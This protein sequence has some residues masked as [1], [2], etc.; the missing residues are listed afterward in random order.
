MIGGTKVRRSSKWPLFVGLAIACAFA[1][2]L[3]W[4]LQQRALTSGTTAAEDKVTA[5]VKQT[6]GPAVSGADLSKPLASS[7]RQRLDQKIDKGV[8]ASGPIVRVRVFSINGQLLYS[9]DAADR[10][11]S[12]AFGYPD[13]LRGA[14]GGALTSLV[15]DDS[16][17]VK[18]GVQSI[19]LLRTYAP[20]KGAKDHTIAVVAVDQRYA[21]LEQ[22]AGSPWHTVQM[23]FAILAVL[24]LGLALYGILRRSSAK[25][26]ASRSGFGTAKKRAANEPAETKRA[27][28][29]AEKS[30]EREGQIREALEDQLEQLRAKLSE[31]D[32]ATAA[33]TREL[34]EQLAAATRRAEQAEAGGPGPSVTERDAAAAQVHDAVE[35]LTQMEA[36]ALSAEAKLSKL[37]G[38]MHEMETA[39][40]QAPPPQELPEDLAAMV[41]ELSEARR[42]ATEQQRRALEQEQRALEASERANVAQH[43][44]EDLAR[45]AEQMSARLAELEQAAVDATRTAAENAQRAD[46]TEALRG[47]LEAKLV[48]VGAR[49]QELETRAAELERRA[50]EAETSGDV[51]RSE[52]A[53]LGAERD[54]LRGRAAAVEMELADAA[55]RLESATSRAEEAERR[56]QEAQR[57]AAEALE[58]SSRAG[59]E[60]QAMAIAAQGDTA[61]QLEAARAEVSMSEAAR[62]AAETRAEEAERRLHQI[63]ADGP[64]A[65][66]QL[67]QVQAELQQAQAEL[68]QAQMIAQQ[69]V[70]QAEAAAQAQIQSVGSP[71]AHPAAPDGSLVADL[72]RELAESH[73]QLEQMEFR[74]QRAYAD[75]EEARARMQAGAPQPADDTSGSEM[76]QVRMDLAH[77]MDR[78]Q[79]AEE[80]A[81]KLEADLLA[82]QHGVR[83]LP[84]AELGP[85]GDDNGASQN[86]DGDGDV[87]ADGKSLRY[88]LA[89][90][91]ARKKLSGDLP[92]LS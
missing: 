61:A 63:E 41:S 49:G 51:V 29:A 3:G 12:A 81:A 58:A 50:A 40:A 89:R 48:Q 10:L 32:E 55:R 90:T 59:S 54:A 39:A 22:A 69:A 8:L 87:D 30:A 38:Q 84:E 73:A 9:T 45:E 72:E 2:A 20:L 24:F 26:S 92:T 71:E 14:A 21:P 65:H 6:V 52:L 5:F 75:A 74:L 83:D 77:A 13:A 4:F 86:G 28:E 78:A 23:G 36:R 67:A 42:S 70:A 46:A 60:A 62:A 57:Q 79:A 18:G 1:V 47:E 16:V 19:R 80:R 88:R 7:V 91:A 34:T 43:R 76:Q 68:Q 11:G 35:R 64:P 27:L 44:A 85:G 66:A 25:R 31:Q 15:D 82:A 17:T 37:E 56:A 53:E 33:A